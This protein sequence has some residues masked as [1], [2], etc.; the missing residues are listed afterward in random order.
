MKGKCD[1]CAQPAV[2]SVEVTK[3]GGR[4]WSKPWMMRR[5][6]RGCRAHVDTALDTLNILAGSFGV[7]HGSARRTTKVEVQ[8][9]SLEEHRAL[10]SKADDALSRIRI[11]KDGT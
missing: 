8:S 5:R 7:L 4:W 6:I 3:D 1:Y 2:I 11:D 9:T 10:V